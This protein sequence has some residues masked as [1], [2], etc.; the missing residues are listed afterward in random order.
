MEVKTDI[1]LSLR[2]VFSIGWSANFGLWNF[3]DILNAQVSYVYKTPK[4][5]GE[6]LKYGLFKGK[7]IF[8]ITGLHRVYDVDPPYCSVL[9]MWCAND[10][11]WC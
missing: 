4:K 6:I 5:R 9:L 2:T 8:Y 7:Y 10:R 11:W 3:G 1:S